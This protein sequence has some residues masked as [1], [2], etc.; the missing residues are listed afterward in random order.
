MKYSY[1][2][3]NVLQNDSNTQNTIYPSLYIS[4]FSLKN[5][6]NEIILKILYA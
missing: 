4:F 1:G 5:H 3:F 6:G 2:N